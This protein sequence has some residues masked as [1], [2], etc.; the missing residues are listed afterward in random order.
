MKC[1]E[2]LMPV[3]MQPIAICAFLLGISA[4]PSRLAAQQPYPQSQEG[5]SAIWQ[6]ASSQVN[7]V[8]IVDAKPFYNP[9]TN[10]ICSVINTILTS[11]SE[12]HCGTTNPRG[13]V[14]D[15]RGISSSGS[16]LQCNSNPFDGS[17]CQGQ[18]FDGDKL[19]ATVLLPAT[20][21][22][23]KQPWILPTNARVIGEGRNLTTI[24]AC[25]N[26]TCGSNF[27][28]TDMIQMGSSTLCP[29]PG[30]TCPGVGIEHLT[31]DAQNSASLNG[32]HDVLA[33]EL[34]YVRDVSLTNIA[35]T[36][37]LIN[38]GNSGPYS[39]ISFSGSG[40]SA[41]IVGHNTRG[42]HGLTCTGTGTGGSAVLLD[43]P[44]SSI[45]DVYISG[46]YQN[47]I[48]V[49]ANGPAQGDI[50]FNINAAT[51]VTNV[52]AISNAGNPPNV[53]DLTVMGVTTSN[54]SG[55]VPTIADNLTNTFLH[56]VS[57]GMYVLGEPVT[58]NNSAIGY[59]RVTTSPS[60]PAWFV[61][62][63]APSSSCSTGSLYS[64]S[65]GPSGS[66]L[67]ACVN[68]TWQSVR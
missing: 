18:V 28:G 46:A 57:V 12:F 6:S 10:D 59:T 24:Q 41:Q 26:G 14:I 35:G 47:G 22:Q 54:S 42:I 25:T 30:N 45:E 40:T 65:S 55:S 19:T 8:A 64:N 56:D 49:G 20:T 61:G 17:A 39:N 4:V 2:R 29:A 5:Q 48:L 60:V 68:G 67:S 36:G 13:V 16:A 66:T 33:Q 53:S 15:A 34:S 63:G 32:I 37:L 3:W 62:N 58:V 21:I 51:N 52:V 31:M 38:G 1:T 43:A 50:L 23:I 11:S 9:P 7:T 27:N 44:Q